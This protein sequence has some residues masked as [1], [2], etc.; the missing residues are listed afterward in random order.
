MRFQGF[1]YVIDWSWLVIIPTVAI[2]FNE[3]V[4]MEKNFRISFHWL[5]W[6]C[7]FAWIEVEHEQEKPH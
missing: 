7:R 1:S 2:I 5:G 3:P 6:H 4:Y